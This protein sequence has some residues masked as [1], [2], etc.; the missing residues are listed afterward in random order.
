MN[1]AENIDLIAMSIVAVI[2]AFLLGYGFGFVDGKDS[3]RRL[4]RSS[5]KEDLKEE[6]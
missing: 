5:R 4:L 3:M 1:W 2:T 6:S